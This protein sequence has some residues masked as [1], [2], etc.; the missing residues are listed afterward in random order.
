MTIAPEPFRTACLEVLHEAII[1]ARAMAGTGNFE[2]DQLKD[3]MS[4]VHNIPHSLNDWERCD[5]DKLRRS[6]LW[7]DGRWAWPNLTKLYDDSIAGTPPT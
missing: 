4:A 7:Y 1:N 2:K 5:Q 3:L 6:L